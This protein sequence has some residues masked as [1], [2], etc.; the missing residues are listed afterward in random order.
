MFRCKTEGFTLIELL[1]TMVI[2]ALTV[3]LVGPSIFKWLESRQVAASK[4]ELV[5]AFALLPLKANRSETVFVID[6][7]VQ[8]HLPN[9]MEIEFVQPVRILNNG[10]CEG[11]QFKLMLNNKIFNYRVLPPFCELQEIAHK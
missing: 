4:S 10:Y 9:E 3:G 11:G 8:L 2:I 6:N 5:S 7:K 1:V